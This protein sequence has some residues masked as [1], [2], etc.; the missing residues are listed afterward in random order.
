MNHSCIN[1]VVGLIFFILTIHFMVYPVCA[2]YCITPIESLTVVDKCLPFTPSHYIAVLFGHDTIIDLWHCS[3]TCHDPWNSQDELSLRLEMER[4]IR[5]NR[6]V[7]MFPEAYQFVKDE[8]MRLTNNL[9]GDSQHPQSLTNIRAILANDTLKDMPWLLVSNETLK[10]AHIFYHRYVKQRPIVRVL[11]LTKDTGTPDMI[12]AYLRRVSDWWIETERRVLQ[13]PRA[14]APF[15][16][17]ISLDP[18][19]GP[20]LSSTDPAALEWLSRRNWTFN[21]NKGRNYPKHRQFLLTPSRIPLPTA[22][23]YY[24]KEDCAV[25]EVFGVAFD[26]L[27][28]LYRR[29]CGYG[30][31]SIV[32]CSPLVIFIRSGVDTVPRKV[33]TLMLHGLQLPL[34]SQ[35][36]AYFPVIFDVLALLILNDSFEG[37]DVSLG[38][39]PQVVEVLVKILLRMVDWDIVEPR[40]LSPAEAAQYELE[41]KMAEKEWSESF[42]NTRNITNINDTTSTTENNSHHDDAYDHHHHHKKKMRNRTRR[43]R[44]VVTLESELR[45]VVKFHVNELWGNNSAKVETLG[46]LSSSMTEPQWFKTMCILLTLFW[47]VLIVWKPG[48]TNS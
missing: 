37:V 41:E 21:S 46:P 44:T 11:H 40:R 4:W 8:L 13:D 43:R 35:V 32:S 22:L 24:Y 15:L 27:P 39:Q 26:L 6:T 2:A 38:Y 28:L 12:Y 47:F 34:S 19:V 14:V 7:G 1:G 3:A 31:L 29:M 23:V 5:A 36:P 20:P 42:T 9:Q 10:E 18:L 45:R 30:H 17:W 25:C 33:P 48:N 16:P